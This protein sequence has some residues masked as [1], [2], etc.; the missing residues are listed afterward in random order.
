MCPTRGSSRSVAAAPWQTP[1]TT[2][3]PCGQRIAQSTCCTIT[4]VDASAWLEPDLIPKPGGDYFDVYDYTYV[5][6]QRQPI[7]RFYAALK[8]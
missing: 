5:M 8:S 3:S 4:D 6:E 1:I 2:F 7:A